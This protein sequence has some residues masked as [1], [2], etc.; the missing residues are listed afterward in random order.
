M[1]PERLI[2]NV[3]MKKSH[4]KSAVSRHNHGQVWS[5]AHCLLFSVM[6]QSADRSALASV[7]LTSFR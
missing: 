3:R 6:G 7:C 4:V 2:A 5:G 1:R